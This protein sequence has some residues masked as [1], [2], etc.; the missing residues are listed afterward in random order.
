LLYLGIATP[1][2]YLK[3]SILWRELSSQLASDTFWLCYIY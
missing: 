1:L 2:S 3:V